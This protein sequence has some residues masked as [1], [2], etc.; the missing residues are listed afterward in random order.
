MKAI[1]IFINKKKLN[2]VVNK[3]I[4]I[5]KKLQLSMIM[6]KT[7]RILKKTINLKI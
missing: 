6:S 3:K 4:I 2:R 5:K 7:K 1:L